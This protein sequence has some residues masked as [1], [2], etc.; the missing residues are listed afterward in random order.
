MEVAVQTPAIR[1]WRYSYT[2]VHRQAT[3]YCKMSFDLHI[4]MY[5][6]IYIYVDTNIHT[7]VHTHIGHTH[8]QDSNTI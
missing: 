5:I 6:A 1:R 7:N 3:E 8:I 4:C 2:L